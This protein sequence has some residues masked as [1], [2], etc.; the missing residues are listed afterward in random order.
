MSSYLNFAIQKSS[1]YLIRARDAFVTVPLVSCLACETYVLEHKSIR[2]VLISTVVVEQIYLC[3]LEKKPIM[4]KQ[5]HTVIEKFCSCLVFMNGKM[6][7]SSLDLYI[8]LTQQ[9][10]IYQEEVFR[11]LYSKQ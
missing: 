4:F 10:S 9:T 7:K 2:Y 6:S 11:K 3:S 8:G 1:M 5:T